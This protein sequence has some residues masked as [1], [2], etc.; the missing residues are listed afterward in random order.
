MIVILLEPS[1]HL[2]L[3]VR[4]SGALDYLDDGV[5]A[6]H[7]HPVVEVR[8]AVGVRTVLHEQTLGTVCVEGNL[9]C[10]CA[11][12]TYEARGVHVLTVVLCW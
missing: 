6:Y 2:T 9:G 8:F 7:L 5:D 4:L 12:E 11:H 10:F 1:R 3:A